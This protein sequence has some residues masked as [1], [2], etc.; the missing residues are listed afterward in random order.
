MKGP[1]LVQRN[2][3]RTG[4]GFLGLG[5]D[6]ARRAQAPKAAPRMQR[7][8]AVDLNAGSVWSPAIG[9]DPASPEE[10][11]E[12]NGALQDK[13]RA[14][15]AADLA[16]YPQHADVPVRRNAFGDPSKSVTWLLVD[17]DTGIVWSTVDGC[18]P[19]T[20]VQLGHLYRVLQ[21]DVQVQVAQ[22]EGLGAIGPV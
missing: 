6:F 17:L 11:S 1:T 10:M 15:A 21:L 12:L 19:A 4:G 7:W 5:F 22:G 8:L 14:R 18:S 3:N 9:W 2:T 13:A 20:P 16:D